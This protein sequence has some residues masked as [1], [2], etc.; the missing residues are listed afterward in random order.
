MNLFS[1]I[2]V[3]IVGIVLLEPSPCGHFIILCEWILF[4]VASPHV[5]LV[6]LGSL[7]FC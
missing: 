6:V 7:D 4:N 5:L 1:V 2:C 3:R